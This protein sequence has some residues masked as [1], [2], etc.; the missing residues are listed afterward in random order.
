MNDVHYP[1]IL[2]GVGKDNR[3]DEP[4]FTLTKQKRPKEVGKCPSSSVHV[5]TDNAL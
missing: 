3:R 4:H 1:I 2:K 5:G